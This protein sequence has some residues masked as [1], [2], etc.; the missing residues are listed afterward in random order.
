MAV[1]VRNAI[2]VLFGD[3]AVF[4]SLVLTRTYN[5]TLAAA[6]VPW[7]D[8]YAFVSD[9]IRH[10]SGRRTDISDHLVPLFIEARLEWRRKLDIVRWTKFQFS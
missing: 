10:T 8:G 5:A 3:P 1:S 6:R 2:D 7:F 9:I 4:L